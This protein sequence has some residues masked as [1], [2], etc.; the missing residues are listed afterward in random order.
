MTVTR[1]MMADRLKDYLQGSCTLGEIVFWAE[2]M[3][4]EGEFEE[5]NFDLVRDAVVRLGVSDV[6][7]FGLTWEEISG[8]LE[9]LGY[10][11]KV[12]FEAAR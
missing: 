1:E 12:E 2:E 3:M 10:R 7:A 9:T 6:A 11:A 5:R 4:A 8:L